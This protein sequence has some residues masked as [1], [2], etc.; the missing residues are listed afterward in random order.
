MKHVTPPE[1]SLGNT[2]QQMLHLMLRASGLPP[3]AWPALLDASDLA[4]ELDNP[5]GQV[6][7]TD[8]MRIGN[9][10]I[11]TGNCGPRLGLLMGQHYRDTDHGLPAQIAR[12][13][14]TIGAAIQCLAH[15]SPLTTRYYRGA[16]RLLHGS[17]PAIRLYSLETYSS[18]CPFVIDGVMAI[19]TRLLRDLSGRNDIIKAVSLEYPQCHYHEAVQRYFR[20][21]VSYGEP[22]NQLTLH[23]AA[24]GWP[25]QRQEPQLHAQLCRLGDELLKE[26]MDCNTIAGSVRQWLTSRLEGGVPTLAECAAAIGMPD[27]TLRRKLAN[28][29]A[30][31]QVVLDDLRHELARAHLDGT[32]L[33]ISEIGFMVGFGSTGSFQR[34]FKRWPG[35][36]VGE[37]RRRIIEKRR[38]RTSGSVSR[39]GHTRFPSAPGCPA[40][41][42]AHSLRPATP[43]HNPLKLQD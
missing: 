37:Y 30:R 27:W 9:T 2:S 11:R 41:H 40:T 32:A 19:W 8:F 42:P 33:S 10:L 21:P 25:V 39:D 17:P 28:E 3:A 1:L 16:P 38:L 35:M 20:A 26:M 34:A 24:L 18:G 5:D 7:L 14:P 22:H 43:R 6:H 13:A 12:T 36:A 23:P 15:Y 29:G 4:Q 31:Y